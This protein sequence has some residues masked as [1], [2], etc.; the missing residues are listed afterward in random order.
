MI[1]ALIAH[2]TAGQ[3]AEFRIDDVKKLTGG[4]LITLAPIPQELGQVL[5]GFLYGCH[6]TQV[7]VI[8]LS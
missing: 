7:D 6:S 5:V 4:A 1:T 3:P 2:V 8:V